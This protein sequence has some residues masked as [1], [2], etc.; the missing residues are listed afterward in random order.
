MSSEN[1]AGKK[2]RCV[3]TSSAFSNFV[4]KLRLLLLVIALPSLPL[5]QTACSH[6]LPVPKESSLATSLLH[7]PPILR[8]YKDQEIYTRDGKYIPQQDEVWHSDARY[9]QLE[10]KLLDALAVIEKNK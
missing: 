10:Q 4:N 2:M 9:R 7:Q 8:I 1:S 6:A 5:L 3:P